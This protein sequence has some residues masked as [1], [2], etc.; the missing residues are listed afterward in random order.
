[1]TGA[2][3]E[4]RSRARTRHLVASLEAETVRWTEATGPGEPLEKHHSQVAC[5][6]RLL[7]TCLR[8]LDGL[9]DR[10]LTEP[11]LDLHHVWD[12]FR[13]KLVL[14]CLPQYRD[15]LETA[16]ELA[17]ACYQ[18]APAAAGTGPGVPP[19]VFLNRAEV[20]F[21]VGRGHD[22]REL[23]PGAVRTRSGEAAAGTLPF[24]IIGVPWH[25]TEHLPGLLTVAHE[26]GHH[27]EDDC[28]LGLAL[29]ARVRGSGLPSERQRLWEDWV[30]E[31]FADVCACLACGPAYLDT[32]SDA[33]ADLPPLA[34][35][36]YPP[37]ELR[38]RAC[39]S[40]FEPTA[41]GAGERP[42]EGPGEPSGE[43]G[44]SD[45]AA[46]VVR[47]LTAD[48]YAELG[49]RT[50][51][52]VLTCAEAWEPE[53]AAGRLLAG[54]P[55]GTADARASLASAAAAFARDPAGYD[56]M[57]VGRRVVRE[58]LDHRPKGPRAATPAPEAADR[59]AT[60][61]GHLLAGLL[62][63]TGSSAG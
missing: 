47:A 38:L 5:L 2:D 27:V 62:T 3:R 61:A 10:E 13:G 20:P 43:Q 31:V 39:R 32:L 63:R 15:F 21:A 51:P 7:R 25:Q 16:D 55:S 26:A 59:R 24:P 35:G 58:V 46:V 11:V 36:G 6:V 23:L 14:R 4:A 49:G 56:A 50:L 53:V 41:P 33:L 48:G 54:M 34:F 29:R 19:L 45:E 12:F 57:G 60:A 1:M 52:S 22:Y 30:T 42:G 18:P 9:P 8:D 37:K 40:V 28:G 17:W 44:P